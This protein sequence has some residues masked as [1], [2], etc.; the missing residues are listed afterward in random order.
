MRIGVSVVLIVLGAILAFALG[1]AVPFVNLIVIG[2]ILIAAGLVG[3]LFTGPMSIPRLGNRLRGVRTAVVRQGI[4]VSV[5]L[6]ALGAVLA[7]AV[8]SRIAPSANLVASGYILVAAGIIGLIVL[9][10][11]F[12]PR[13]K[14]E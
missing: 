8:G 10:I 14:G 2:F 1:D 3:L 6:I 7:F 11:L 12:A 9:I 4:A 13:H 5:F